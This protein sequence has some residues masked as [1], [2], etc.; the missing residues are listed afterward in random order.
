MKG[1]D[2]FAKI[3]FN[4]FNWPTC[5]NEIQVKVIASCCERDHCVATEYSLSRICFVL[6]T[7][8][9]FNSEQQKKM[10]KIS[11]FSNNRLKKEREKYRKYYHLVTMAM[12]IGIVRLQ[13]S[14]N[15]SQHSKLLGS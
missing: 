13:S 2:G 5:T 7:Q 12:K 11:N 15:K 4:I 6:R 10:K 14:D 9:G 3:H 1:L 8:L